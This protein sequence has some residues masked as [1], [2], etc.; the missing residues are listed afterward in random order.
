MEMEFLVTSVAADGVA[1]HTEVFAI[2][3]A[4]GAIARLDELT[5]T[6]GELLTGGETLYTTWN[7][8]LAAVVRDGEAG[9]YDAIF[10]RDFAGYDHVNHQ[11]ITREQYLD[12][13][14]RVARMPGVQLAMR[15]VVTLGNRHGVTWCRYSY[16]KGAAAGAWA[17]VG[18]G[19][20]AFL[21]V[22][23]AT[24]AG[25]LTSEHFGEDDVFS[26]LERAEELYQEDEA[27]GDALAGSRRRA[28][29]WRAWRASFRDWDELKRYF[30]PDAVLIDRRPSSA[31]PRRGPD[32]IVEW[33]KAATELAAD[34][35]VTIT[36][37][38]LLHDD[39]VVMSMRGT[40][41]TEHDTEVEMVFTVAAL[42]SDAGITR[43]E[44]FPVDAMD[45][46]LASVQRA[47]T[48]T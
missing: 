17:D 14:E 20:T 30:T 27:T 8:A 39:A 31:P 29:L 42:L 44:Y 6:H 9:V 19:E 4:A 5:R 40:A 48:G 41:R 38:H 3:D 43:L 2:D 36:A 12:M 10:H 45:A 26:A 16:P 11:P 7:R 25:L 22:G 13:S 37:V 32:E 18:G 46:A 33:G 21:S 24:E 35:S 15:L 47:G 28:M 1:R 34:D 23:R